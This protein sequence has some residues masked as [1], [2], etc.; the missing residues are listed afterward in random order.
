MLPLKESGSFFGFEDVSTPIC[1]GS[2]ILSFG[3]LF[4][5]TFVSFI[6]KINLNLDASSGVSSTVLTKNPSREHLS[7]V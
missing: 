2:S 6:W 4:M 1:E 7:E 3:S 5:F